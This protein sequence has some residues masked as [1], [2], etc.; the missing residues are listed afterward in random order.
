MVIGRTLETRNTERG[1]TR[2]DN[3]VFG[4]HRIRKV[5]DNNLGWASFKFGFVIL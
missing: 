2:R 1:T 3:Y 4:P 5:R